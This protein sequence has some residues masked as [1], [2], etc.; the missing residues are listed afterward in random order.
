MMVLEA[1]TGKLAALILKFMGSETQFV[2]VFFTVR[3]YDLTG[4]FENKGETW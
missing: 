4:M 2:V 1:A 3:L